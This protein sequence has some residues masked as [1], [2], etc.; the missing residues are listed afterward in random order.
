MLGS[1]RTHSTRLLQR[2]LRRAVMHETRSIGEGRLAAH[3]RRN[4]FTAETQRTQRAAE[5]FHRLVF[6]F[7]CHL[8]VLCASPVNQLHRPPWAA[9][10][11]SPPFLRNPTLRPALASACRRPPF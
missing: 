6:L 4:A 8:S 7:L 10:R 1:T 9:N 3:C 2:A 5:E 11:T